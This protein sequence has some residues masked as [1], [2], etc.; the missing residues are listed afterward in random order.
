MLS[1]SLH[2][3]FLSQFS[4]S[5]LQAEQLQAAESIVVLTQTPGMINIFF[6]FFSLPLLSFIHAL[7][8]SYSIGFRRCS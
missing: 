6:S 5:A 8:A 1:L 4:L 7:F 2:V 3:F